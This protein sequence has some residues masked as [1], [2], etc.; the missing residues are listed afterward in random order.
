MEK[1][2]I[3]QS[4][5]N[6]DFKA[7]KE[8]VTDVLYSKISDRVEEARTVIASKLFTESSD[9]AAFKAQINHAD[10]DGYQEEM[11]KAGKDSDDDDEPHGGEFLVDLKFLEGNDTELKN[12]RVSGISKNDVESRLNNFFGKGKFE[13]QDIK[14]NEKQ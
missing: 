6:G 9:D 2:N 10:K 8:H 1:K 4:L 13:I 12:F 14:I 7:F 11:E 3:I 5:L